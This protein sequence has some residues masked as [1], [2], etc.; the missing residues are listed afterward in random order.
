MTG[1]ELNTI[2]RRYTGT[3]T[4]SYTA[5]NCLLDVNNIK[6]DFAARI[7][8]RNEEAFI[9]PTLYDLVA[10][11]ITAREYPLPDDMLS[12][13]ATVEIAVDSAISPL[14]YVPVRPYPGGLQSALVNTGGLTE[15]KIIQ[16]F[17]NTKPFYFITRK[18]IYILSGTL[19][20]VTS[21]LKVRYRLYP[22]DLANLSGS[23]GLHVDPTTTSFGMPLQFHELWARAVSILWKSQR[24]KP[25]PLSKKELDFDND[26]ELA[27][28]AFEENDLAEE[29]I[30][31]LPSADSPSVLGANL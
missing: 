13:I 20:A 29:H 7:A 1:S 4:T 15:A 3:D 9:I 28:Q 23:T 10:S 12:H 11:S 2:I 8:Q 21:G 14:G 31:S 22:A 18:G 26:F 6:N 25:M 27:L 5:A 19:S 24:P 17:T 30:G 16:V